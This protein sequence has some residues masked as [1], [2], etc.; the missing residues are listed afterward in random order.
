MTND[1]VCLSIRIDAPDDLEEWINKLVLKFG[2]DTYPTTT[3]E[4]QDYIAI[5]DGRGG[6]DFELERFGLNVGDSFQLFYPG[7]AK[8]N[9]LTLNLVV[10]AEE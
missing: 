8:Y 2:D 3:I 6:A 7:N 9:P 1:G 10:P 4:G 5:T